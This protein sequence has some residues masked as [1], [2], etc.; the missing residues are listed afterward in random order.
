M[1]SARLERL[2]VSHRRSWQKD[3]RFIYF[4]GFLRR[5]SMKLK[6]N[7]VIKLQID[8]KRKFQ[9]KLDVVEWARL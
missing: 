6:E 8:E 4:I 9:G 7:S 5:K 2:V 3:Q 1:E